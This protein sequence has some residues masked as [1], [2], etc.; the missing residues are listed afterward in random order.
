MGK[1]TKRLLILGP[2]L[3]LAGVLGAP[4]LSADRF[5]EQVR[6][7]LE[8]VLHRKVEVQGEAR[9]QLYPRPGVSLSRVVIHELPELGVEPI[10]YMDYP[11]SSLDVSLSLFP[12][13]LGRISVTGVRLVAPSLNL[14]KAIDG[15]WTF[16]ALLDKAMGE[17]R[18]AG[19]DLD[20]L[21]VR[22]G[23]LNI[24]IGNVKSVF[25]LRDADLRIE[26]DSTNR[27][28]YGITIAGDPARTDRTVSSF[29]R[30]TGRGMLTLDRGDVEPR[31]NLNLTI[32]RTP[33]A[34]IVTA[35]E[36][37]NVG[38]G[39]FVASQAKL[40]GPLSAVAI[41]GRIEL[42]E[43]ER[44]RW[45]FPRAASARG[46]G[47]TGLLDWPGQELRLR[48]RDTDAAAVPLALRM[49]AADLF[50]KPSWAV[51]MGIDQA[52]LASVRALA[53]ELGFSLPSETPVEGGLSGV[54]G[55]SSKHGTHGQVQISQA[56]VAVPEL[57][58]VQLASARVLVDNHR[59]RVPAAEIRFS[60]N[61]AVTVETAV[62]STTGAREV[63]VAS[64]G[65]PVERSRQL[66][67]YLSGGADPPFFD[68]CRQGNWAGSVRFEQDAKGTGT[69]SGDLRVTGAVCT[70]DGVAEPANV[71][72][73]QVSIRGPA[74]QARRVAVRIGKL[75]L[76]AEADH[77]PLRR[78]HTRLKL[79]ATEVA[80]GEIER[81]LRPS[82][83]REGGFLSRT[84]GR[85][86]PL[87]EWLSQRRLD[88]QVRIAVLTAGEQRWE[89]VEARL[90]WD[91]ATIDA[92]QLGAAWL[93]GAVTGRFQ[94]AVSGAEPAYRGHFNF[95]NLAVRE[96]H[97][98][99]DADWDTSGTGG[100][101]LAA[102]LQSQGKFSVRGNPLLAADPPWESAT[103]A[104]TLVGPRIQLPNLQWTSGGESWQGQGGAGADG[105]LQLESS[106]AG[107][108]TRTV[109]GSGRLW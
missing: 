108:A 109:R 38:L 35:M 68:R 19:F 4:Y 51:L 40:T 64:A 47:Y 1:Q 63:A 7:N 27:N 91:G 21:E 99:A 15:A 16:Q 37:R 78:R 105:R 45:L 6:V 41:E 77:D 28:H 75:A 86:A 18:A 33:I 102:R 49:R 80:A 46:L 14:T 10:A 56:S 62:D 98:D 84:L 67:K 92:S 93:R 59:W 5:K 66:W 90:A 29:G 44:F 88:A 26:A 101:G 79:V 20:A 34:E 17:G 85:T 39:G 30:L 22:G 54:L 96:G 48:T 43:A 9:F 52:P 104:F 72:S 36:G 42:N 3:M 73:A 71:D 57:P 97:L 95:V 65:L 8:R 2:I 69:W 81:L 25:Y 55:Y 53:G 60:P 106:G 103:G 100:V 87:P 89:G 74:M 94:A 58:P 24:K 50:R 13:L 107:G 70:L 31:I 12:L 83:R 23:R 61:E 11:E 32:D 76:T 82:L